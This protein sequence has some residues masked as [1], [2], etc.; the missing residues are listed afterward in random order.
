[1]KTDLENQISKSNLQGR[2]TQS[3]IFLQK[4]NRY[5]SYR[6][7]MLCLYQFLLLQVQDVINGEGAQCAGDYFY[8]NAVF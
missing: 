5:F 7:W 4:F 1:M 6:D 8:S 3:F 2:L